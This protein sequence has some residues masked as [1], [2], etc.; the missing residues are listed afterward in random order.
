MTGVQTCALPISIAEANGVQT[1]TVAF[2]AAAYSADSSTA[3]GD[4]PAN[5]PIDSIFRVA[6]G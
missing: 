5:C 6:L 3:G 2:E 4:L 1:Y